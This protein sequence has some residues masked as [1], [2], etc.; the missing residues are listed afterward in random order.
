MAPAPPWITIP[1]R[2][3]ATRLPP[4]SVGRP[5]GTGPGSGAGAGVHAGI[6]ASAAIHRN[7][8]VRIMGVLGRNSGC[9]CDRP[10][11]R[12]AGGGHNAGS[13]YR[14]FC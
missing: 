6:A 10:N 14:N 9:G 12:G 4:R 2:G 13:E 11:L 8:V 5:G 1:Q 3:G 7:R